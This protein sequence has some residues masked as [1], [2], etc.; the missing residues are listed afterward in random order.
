MSQQG[1]YVPK[2]AYFGAKIAVFG[3]NIIIT[4][5][6]AKVLVYTYQETNEAPRSH[7]FIGSA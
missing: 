1:L 7:C 2:K 6:G 5:E 4:F 3:P